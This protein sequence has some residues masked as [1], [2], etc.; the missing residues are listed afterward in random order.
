MENLDPNDPLSV[1]MRS[2]AG[3]GDQFHRRLIRN[4]LSRRRFIEPSTSERNRPSSAQGW[5]DR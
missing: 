5:S 4:S 1:Y 2:S 3:G